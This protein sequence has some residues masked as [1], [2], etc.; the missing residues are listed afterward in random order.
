MTSSLPAV[1]ALNQRYF[2]DYPHEAARQLESLPPQE[3][4]NCSPGQPPHEWCGWHCSLRMAL[5]GARAVAK[6]WRA[7]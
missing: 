7:I 3:M 2:L 4:P 1:L 6:R 5:R